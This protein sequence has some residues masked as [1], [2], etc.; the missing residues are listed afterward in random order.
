MRLELHR[1]SPAMV[2]SCVALALALAGT[3]FAAVSALPAGSVGTAQ[4]KKHAVTSAKIATDA[5]TGAKISDGAITKAKL[6]PDAVGHGKIAGNAVT[7]A[8][9]ADHSLLAVDFAPGQLPA[10]TVGKLALYTGS[11]SVPKANSS[12]VGVR[13]PAGQQAVSGGAVWA[14]KGDLALTVVYLGP[15]YDPSAG[16]AT[17]WVARGRNSTTRPRQFIVQVLCGTA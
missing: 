7:S 17:G 5:V 14:D 10:G 12:E 2:V 4:L 15:V 1:P 9:V 6:A 16:I 13:C 11:T 8:K 3:S